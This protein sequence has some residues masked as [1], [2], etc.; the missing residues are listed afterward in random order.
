M[1][2]VVYSYLLFSL[3]TLILLSCSSSES[4]KLKTEKESVFPDTSEISPATMPLG[5]DQEAWLANRYG[6]AAG[7]VEYEIRSGETTT[8]RTTYFAEHGFREAHYLNFGTEQNPLQHITIIDRGKIAAKGPGDPEPL[9][10]AW[11]PDPHQTL[12]NFRN[13]TQ[14]MRNLFGLEE[15]ASKNILGKECEGYR[16]NIGESV[17]EIWVWEGIML[18]SEI[19]GAPDKHIPSMVVQAVSIDTSRV[20]NDRQFSIE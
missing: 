1:I 10:G 9:L 17:S 13:L 20:P 16:L 12:P 5:S 15:L 6:P 3:S 8:R 18:Y 11:Q 2:R 7:R 4:E 14:E 19:K